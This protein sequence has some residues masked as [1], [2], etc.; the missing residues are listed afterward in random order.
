[1]CTTDTLTLHFEKIDL[2]V[3]TSYLKGS[4]FAAGLLKDLA[5]A[6]GLLKGPTFAYGL[7]KG[8]TFSAGLLK[9]FAFAAGHQRGSTFAA[10]LQ[11]GSICLSC[12]LADFQRI[13]TGLVIPQ[14]AHLRSLSPPCPQAARLR[15]LAPSPPCPQAARLRSP[16]LL[17]PSFSSR[18]TC[19]WYHKIPI[20][21][22]IV[23]S[24]N[25]NLHWGYDWSDSDSGTSH[26]GHLVYLIFSN[27]LFTK[28][29][30]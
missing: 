3:L 5:F 19:P 23:K 17:S 14:A 26:F 27:W 24:L 18:A 4:A 29:K 11:R 15:S 16:A 28:N 25:I 2:A 7:L 9:G 21:Y 13:S 1:M 6:I 8:S 22:S 12:L 10:T 20:V 30:F